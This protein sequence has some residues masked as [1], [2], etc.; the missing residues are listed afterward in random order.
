MHFSG[1]AEQIAK[2]NFRSLRSHLR[3]AFG[4]PISCSLRSHQPF[5]RT[6]QT[7][8]PPLRTKLLTFKA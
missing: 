1:E 8:A 5:A 7:P 2:K 4:L 3:E 6:S